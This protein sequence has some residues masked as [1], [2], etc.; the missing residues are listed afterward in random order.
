MPNLKLMKTDKS[1]HR[2]IFQLDIIML[3]TNNKL[4]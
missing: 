2:E 1:T 4:S 3:Q